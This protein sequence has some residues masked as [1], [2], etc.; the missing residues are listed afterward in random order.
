LETG[1][2]GRKDNTGLICT[3][4]KVAVPVRMSAR[5]L[6]TPSNFVTAVCA[7]AISFAVFVSA[8]PATAV[9][10]KEELVLLLQQHPQLRAGKDSVAAATEGVNFARSLY[11]P[12]ISLAGDS[13]YKIIDSPSTRGTGKNFSRGFEKMTMTVTQNLFDGSRKDYDKNSAEL[14]K[15]SVEGSFEE[16]RQALLL[17]AANIYVDILRQVSLVRLAH[18]SESAIAYQLDLEDERV[19][20]G[21]GTAVDVL[22]S[23][24]RLQRSKEQRIVFEGNLRDSVTRYT[25]LF[26]HPPIIEEM[27]DP[28]LDY[29]LV[30]TDIDVAVSAALAA[31]P[32]VVNSNRQIDIARMRQRSAKSDYF[33]RVDVVGSAN[34]E[35]DREGTIGSRRDYSVTVQATWNL[36]SGFSTRSTIAEAAHSYSASINN[37]LFVNRRIE[38]EVRI[39]WQSMLTACDRRLLLANAVLISAEVHGSRV[40][41]QEAGQETTINVLDAEGEVFNAEINEV[42][43]RFDE[44]LAI[45]RLA[46]ARGLNLVDILDLEYS[47]EVREDAKKR[48]EDRCFG[49]LKTVAHRTLEDAKAPAPAD[50]FAAPVNGEDDEDAANPFAAPEKG[51]DSS[52]EEAANP[53]AKPSDDG[54]AEEAENPFAA[55]EQDDID[56]ED[57]NDASTSN[58]FASSDNE[59]DA[60]DD[61]G[62]SLKKSDDKPEA[63]KLEDELEEDDDNVSRESSQN[64]SDGDDNDDAENSPLKELETE[65]D[66]ELTSDDKVSTLFAPQNDASETGKTETEWDDELKKSK[67]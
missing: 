64:D 67:Q 27:E 47:E 62:L 4:T 8:L 29:V 28:L 15:G 25:Q 55:K 63:K 41:L 34:Y 61:D 20:R 32:L 16:T 11:L 65:E 50:P 18:K 12:T 35:D 40:R 45:Y 60:D 53:F 10:L 33:P 13:G 23:K 9:T 44:K 31:N 2:T 19:K 51:E 36:F 30:P 43:A 39:S 59:D 56:T 38:E 49:R 17:Q 22:L 66:D 58:P 48:Y 14:N 57:D 1:L 42:G 6:A 21:G 5:Q 3:A 7:T 54:E 52:D 37:H 26:G 46:I 24:T